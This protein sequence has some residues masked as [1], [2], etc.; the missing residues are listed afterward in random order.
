[1]KERIYILES[2]VKNDLESEHNS[3]LKKDRQI[4]PSKNKKHFK[5]SCKQRLIRRVGYW[6]KAT[7][8]GNKYKKAA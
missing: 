8:I 3:C 6:K 7:K 4:M 5:I 2:P 1:M